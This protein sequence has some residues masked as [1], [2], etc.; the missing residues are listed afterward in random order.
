MNIANTKPDAPLLP[1]GQPN[2]CLP[3]LCKPV[4]TEEQSQ[5][6][7]GEVGVFRAC[8]REAENSV[9]QGELTQSSQSGVA[10]GFSHPALSPELF[11]LTSPPIYTLLQYLPSWAL[12]SSPTESNHFPC[13]GSSTHCR[14][15]WGP[16][17]PYSHWPQIRAGPEN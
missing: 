10:L 5:A 8:H 1:S 9:L 3:E 16:P 11:L 6:P 7:L 2:T 13:S 15:P 14:M 12:N 4:H 17:T